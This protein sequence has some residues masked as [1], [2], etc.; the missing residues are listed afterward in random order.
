MKVS[1]SQMQQ[2]RSSSQACGV[3]GSPPASRRA[4]SSVAS[5]CSSDDSDDYVGQAIAATM[6]SKSKKKSRRVAP[7]QQEEQKRPR[8]SSDK[9]RSDE[10]TF[11]DG[12]PLDMFHDAQ[13]KLVR[14][15]AEFSVG[16]LSGSLGAYLTLFGASPLKWMV[17]VLLFPIV[18]L[19]VLEFQLLTTTKVSMVEVKNSKRYYLLRFGQGLT[20]GIGFGHFTRNWHS[21][22]MISAAMSVAQWVAVWMAWRAIILHN[23]QIALRQLAVKVRYLGRRWSATG[24]ELPEV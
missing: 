13:T 17:L 8:P 12:S 18:L 21:H 7:Q 14:D 5:S 19:E 22:G 24:S 9:S 20:M 4:A 2:L 3:G 15:V 11:Y 10:D 16:S 23:K 6:N 1:K